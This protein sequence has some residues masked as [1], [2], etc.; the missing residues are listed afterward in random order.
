MKRHVLPLIFMLVAAHEVKPNGG[1]FATSAVKATGHLVP[2]R[3]TRIALESE[4]LHVDLNNESAVVNVEYALFNRGRADRVTYGF[5]LDSVPM[6]FPE[7]EGISEY[8]IRDGAHRL[9]VQKVINEPAEDSQ[10]TEA[11]YEEN[12]RNWYFSEIP[13]AGG[14]RKTLYVNYRVR[15]FATVSGTTKSFRWTR[16]ENAFRYS[17]RPARTWGNGRLRAL[18]IEV[19]TRILQRKKV[20]VKALSPPG[21][22]ERDGILTWDLHDVDLRTMPDLVMNYD[23]TSVAER[24]E[25]GARRLDRRM[26]ESIRASSTLPPTAHT[27]Y[28]VENL[29]DGRS[30]T[31]WIEGRPGIGK[32]EWIEIVFKP[33]VEIRGIGL[34]NGYA[35]S[36]QTLRENG[37]VRKIHMR[38]VPKADWL[39]EN[40]ELHLP[41]A[42]ATQR[43]WPISALD[44]V[45]DAGDSATALKRVR[46][47]ILDGT[48]GTKFEDTAISEL[49]VYGWRKQRL[50]DP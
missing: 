45:F 9:G 7:K 16:S 39:E 25:I 13:F 4:L 10:V 42:M 2:Q 21:A 40:Q 17:F 12:I 37:F 33:G 34:L 44:W 20:P 50:R 27:S 15:T 41:R 6:P 8:E 26:I 11:P 3:K 18:H 30:D 29:L 46:F 49:F 35:K 31:A 1:T 24:E 36:P 28:N 43:D 19:D 48:P 5:P 32:G 14:E 38:C 23:F 22:I 47:T